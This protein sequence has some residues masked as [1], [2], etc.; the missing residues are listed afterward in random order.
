MIWTRRFGTKK[1]QEKKKKQ[2]G[3]KEEKQIPFGSHFDRLYLGWEKDRLGE[4]CVKALL[5][6]SSYD[7]SLSWSFSREHSYAL[8]FSVPYIEWVGYLASILVKTG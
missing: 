1:K 5:F 4:S 7:I 2:K 3:K 8:G 6:F